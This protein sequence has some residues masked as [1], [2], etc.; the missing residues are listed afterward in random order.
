MGISLHR[1]LREEESGSGDRGLEGARD[2]E[3][4]REGSGAS[5]KESMREEE[6]GARAS[7]VAWS[8]TDQMKIDLR[9]VRV[10]FSCWC[11]S[12]LNTLCVGVTPTPPDINKYI[13]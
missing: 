5:V 11:A 9:N 3:G 6:R 1:I 10:P 13:S 4:A 8:L 7:R 12:S 2:I